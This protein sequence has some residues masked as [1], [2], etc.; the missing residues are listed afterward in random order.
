M[1]KLV[2][3]IFA[4]LAAIG[5]QP[6]QAQPAP[7]MAPAYNFGDFKSSTLATKAWQALNDKNLDGV[8]A[9]TNKCIEMY[10]AEAVKMQATLKELPAGDPQK[11]FA[12]W[13]LNDVSTCLYIQGEAYRVADQKDKAKVAFERVVN[14]FSFG[15]A[16]DP[17]NKSFWNPAAGAKD[18]LDMM[19]KGLNL[20][21]GDMRSST[22]VG[23]M[24]GAL[25]KKDLDAGIAYY[26]KLTALYGETAKQMQAGMTEYA[27]ESP[28]KIHSFWA[29]NDVG[30]GTFI[31]GEIYRV[32]GKKED[33]TAMFKKLVNEYLY[34]QCWDPNGW[35]WKP[36]EAAQQK[37]IE[38]DIPVAVKK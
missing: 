28:E 20:D 30:T 27:W 18:K 31:M 37:L 1:K 6:L 26:S 8:L 38:L 12:F 21:F 2:M 11:I 10:G 23:R 14:E 7:A 22:L 36:A 32:A 24:W 16:Y 5:V 33:A 19:A 15:Q 13:A 25:G 35:F 34:A 29:L 3:M 9:Y 4:V 17:A